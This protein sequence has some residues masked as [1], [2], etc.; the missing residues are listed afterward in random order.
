MGE[1]GAFLYVN[2]GTDHIYVED[3][4]NI[5]YTLTPVGALIDGSTIPPIVRRG[6]AHAAFLGN[7]V[8]RLGGGADIL[9]GNDPHRIDFFLA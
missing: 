7:G 1:Y 6:G 2:L 3:Q 4:D 9:R 8:Q 5:T